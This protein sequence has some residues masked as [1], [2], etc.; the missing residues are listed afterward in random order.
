MSKPQYSPGYLASVVATLP[1]DNGK[2][3]LDGQT[4]DFLVKELLAQQEWLNNHERELDGI[5]RKVEDTN[6]M[7]EYTVGLTRRVLP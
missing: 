3:Y 2:V 4:R 6:R 7:L 5:M 1:V